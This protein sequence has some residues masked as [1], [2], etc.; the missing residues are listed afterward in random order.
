MQDFETV[1]L[2]FQVT[3]RAILMKNMPAS[4]EDAI[5]RSKSRNTTKIFISPKILYSSCLRTLTSLGFTHSLLISL[6]L[7]FYQRYF[8]IEILIGEPGRT[9]VKPVPRKYSLFIIVINVI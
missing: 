9:P 2:L 6:L 4:K 1:S 3:L 7:S 5:L 8:K